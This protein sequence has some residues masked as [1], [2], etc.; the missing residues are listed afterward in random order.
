MEKLKER[1]VTEIGIGISFSPLGVL[2]D[3]VIYWSAAMLM[4]YIGLGL[5]TA[6]SVVLFLPF[7]LVLSILRGSYVRR[8]KI[9]TKDEV[10]DK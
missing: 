4:Q 2:I 10:Q 6:D 3:T 5:T 9:L 7:L 1:Y 8:R